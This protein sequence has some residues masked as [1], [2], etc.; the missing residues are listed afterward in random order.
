MLG[1][2]GMGE[3][4]AVYDSKLDRK[5]ALKVLR[6]TSEDFEMRLQRE[7]QAMARLSH[8]NV[9]AVFDTGSVDGQLFL[10]MEFVEGG[11]LRA[12]QRAE[13]RPW[14]AILRMYMDA[15]RGLAAAHAAGLVHRDFKGD[16]VLV[17]ETG[18]AKVTDFG[19]ARAV[20]ISETNDPP[21]AP[22]EESG[23]SAA[24]TSSLPLPGLDSAPSVSLPTMPEEASY[25]SS[26]TSEVTET[27]DLLGT[28]G[29]MAPE[30]YLS[31]EI[32]ERTD[33]FA[34]CVALYEALYG[35]KPFPTGMTESVQ[36]MLADHVKPAPKGSKV[37]AHVHR[38]LLRGLARLSYGRLGCDA[39]ADLP[40]HAY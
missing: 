33:Q 39:Q 22:S 9:V 26:L 21:E 12:W 36:A 23:V 6:S 30:Q 25:S 38:A 8:P 10:A 40:G 28:P 7:A 17:S 27:G 2:G 5:T 35:Q 13:P 24:Y 3:V 34:F 18:V 29:Y 31:E 19:L 37:P 11:T 4:Y 32:D 20:N 1:R 14:R 16:N 15:G